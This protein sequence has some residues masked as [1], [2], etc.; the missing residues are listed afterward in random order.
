M[1]GL[2][3]GSQSSGDST[4]RTQDMKLMAERVKYVITTPL[5]THSPAR[6]PPMTTTLWQPSPAMTWRCLT[7]YALCIADLAQ[8]CRPGDATTLCRQQT[9]AR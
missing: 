6:P 3:S 8:G 7:A 1:G 4:C 2:Q 9:E 5:A